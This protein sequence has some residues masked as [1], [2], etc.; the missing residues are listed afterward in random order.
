MKP[1]CRKQNCVVEAGG[2]SHSPIH[3]AFLPRPS[4][5]CPG[6][7]EEH[8]GTVEHSLKT[9]GPDLKGPASLWFRRRI[10]ACSGKIPGGTF[11]CLE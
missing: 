4:Q 11:G 2:T 8:L 5:R 10:Y 3:S 7:L 6:T 1:Q 9:V